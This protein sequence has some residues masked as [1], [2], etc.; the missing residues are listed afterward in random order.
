MNLREEV[1]PTI[2]LP[3][4][5]CVYN[6][7]GCEFSPSCLN[8]C[9]PLCVYDEPGGRSAMVKRQRA[10]EITRL[11]RQECKSV[12]ELAAIYEV[13]I[14]TVQRVLKASQK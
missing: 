12:R 8:C 2:D 4:E 11:H 3:P 10:A 13:S 5:Y 9:L 7:A 1:K 6:D 14:R